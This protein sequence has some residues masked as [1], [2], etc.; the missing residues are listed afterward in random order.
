MPFSVT[1]SHSPHLH[2]ET[3]RV[4]VIHPRHVHS[5]L[6]DLTARFF[7]ARLVDHALAGVLEI[8]GAFFAIGCD[9][10]DLLV[11][12]VGVPG[13]AGLDGAAAKHL[14]LH[15]HVAA[16]FAVELHVERPD[17]VAREREQQAAVACAIHARNQPHALA[18]TA[19]CARFAE[20]AF[21][22]DDELRG[23]FQRQ[24]GNEHGVGIGAQAGVSLALQDARGIARATARDALRDDLAAFRVDDLHGRPAGLVADELRAVG[25]HANLDTDRFRRQDRRREHHEKQDVQAA[26]GDTSM[27]G[28]NGFCRRLLQ[29]RGWG[30]SKASFAHCAHPPRQADENAHQ[31]LFSPSAHWI[32]SLVQKRALPVPGTRTKEDWDEKRVAPRP[33]AA[34]GDPD[35]LDGTY[36]A[37]GLNLIQLGGQVPTK[38]LAAPLHHETDSRRLPRAYIYRVQISPTFSVFDWFFFSEQTVSSFP[39]V[40]TRSAPILRFFSPEASM[41]FDSLARLGWKP[42]FQQQLSLENLERDAPARVTAVHRSE[43][44]VHD[45]RVERRVP[46]ALIDDEAAV[47]DWLLLDGETGRARRLERQS[48]I[49]RKAAGT[50]VARQVIVANIDTLFIVTSCN[51]DFNESRLERYL[52]LAVESRVFPVV[53]LTK[54]DQCEDAASFRERAA[55]LHAGL[56]VECVNA[57]DPETLAGVRS[58]CGPGQ[59]VAL[60]GSSGVGKSTI[61]NTL[62]GAALETGGIREDDARGRHTTTY[63]SLH[64]LGSGGVLIDTPGMRELQL[65]DAEHGIEAVFAEIAM[66]AANCRF[67]DC[68]HDAEP[69]CAVQAALGSGTLDER[70]WQNWQKLMREQE[71]NARTLSESR[72]HFRTQEKL[73]KDIQRE[74]RKRKG[75]D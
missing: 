15:A 42:F 53:I 14:E 59:T 16:A 34:S 71:R 1:Y 10:Y 31:R 60:V 30:V 69:G 67:A 19:F 5:R 68:G 27:T 22:L 29:S 55:R 72:E 13:A 8:R 24:A 49:S 54:A 36:V 51:A 38:M 9:E 32:P 48:E 73:Y 11:N 61:A 63:R 58:W 56:V 41:P 23:L 40:K 74:R 6:P 62:A 35:S 57:L 28:V 70:R 2:H 64:A 17:D 50:K 4:V 26:H 65:T 47:G 45:G 12:A 37:A 33:L 43:M 21:G 44:A 52:S 75:N 20:R 39:A 25:E 3:S 66:L 18:C 46:V 7:E